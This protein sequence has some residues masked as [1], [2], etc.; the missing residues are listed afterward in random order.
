MK[1]KMIVCVLAMALFFSSF[2]TV[3]AEE[4]YVAQIVYNGETET[5]SS[6]SFL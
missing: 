6:V 1:Q 3:S 4:D 2:V 5:Y